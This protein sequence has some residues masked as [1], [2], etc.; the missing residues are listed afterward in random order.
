VIKLANA[1]N[2]RIARNR[3]I[4]V[5]LPTLV[6]LISQGLKAQS[7]PG[8]QTPANTP[9]QAGSQSQAGTQTQ[10]NSTA[11]T[12]TPAQSNL[13]AKA[14]EPPETGLET[15]SA[16]KS[17]EL[18]RR[19]STES[20]PG[21]G[22]GLYEVKQSAELGGRISRFSGSTAMWDTFV[23][24]GTG[25]RLLEYT[26]NMHAKNHDGLF[27]DDLSF[28]NFGYG[29]DPNNVS[30]LRMNK[31][32]IYDFD[33]TFRRDQNIF[34]YDLFANPLNPTISAPTLTNPNLPVLNSPHEVLLTRRMSD[35]TLRLFPQ[36]RI[37]FKLGYSRIV[38]QGNAYSSTHQGTEGLLLEPTHNTTDR[39][40]FEISVKPIART[41]ISYDQFYT[42]YKGDTTDQLNS[43]PFN[44]PGN[45]PVDLGLPWN[46][47]A[48]QPCAGAIQPTG[49]AN[50]AC[51]GYFAYNISNNRIRNN[52]PTEQL[53]F[54]SSYFH[55]FDF[56]GRVNYSDGRSN[57]PAFLESFN[58]L[59]SR[60]AA[61]SFQ[62]NGFTMS[63]RLSLSADGA[64]TWHLTQRMRL[65]DT[66]RYSTFRIP[67]YW[68][69]TT[70]SLFGATL[71]T[72]PNA[73]SAATCPPPFTAA[74]CPQHTNS[75]GPDILNYQLFS[76]LKQNG[77]VNTVELEY[78]FTKRITGHVGFR[79]EHRD[80]LDIN[81]NLETETFFPNKANRG[82]CVGQPILADGSCK[83]TNTH[84][85]N[86]TIFV[87]I[88][89]F[90]AIAGFS[91]RPVDALRI[92][93]DTE[94]FYADNVFT[95]ISPRHM[96]NYRLRANYKAREWMNFG[97]AVTIFENRDNDFDIGN[98]QHN[99][100]YSVY[101]ELAPPGSI[102]GFDASYDYSD[103]F[104]Q[105][106]ICF[107]AT[108]AP[109]GSITCGA[110]FLS[111]IS[112]YTDK[113]HSFSG[114]FYIHPI[115]RVTASAGYALTST[116]GSTLILNPNAPT[117][118]LSFNYHLPVGALAIHISKNF[119]YK[120]NWNY[121]DYHEKSDPGP[122]L[123]RNFRGN[124][125]T[126][127]LRYSM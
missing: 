99:R 7:P 1:K 44:L 4:Q 20:N 10:S 11:Q 50:P 34:D 103:I 127:S 115:P 72:T 85:A 15:D 88:H 112:T 98:L 63:D 84:P 25:P 39:Y 66:Y 5:F 107:V 23:N 40:Q 30:R 26:L 100:S 94:I 96:Q 31:I 57:L 74:T 62:T 33:F 9:T 78:D 65:I 104:S 70:N 38:N 105:T 22:W 120:A 75:S 91:A 37:Q 35:A 47:A 113:S 29:G 64:M 24:M 2:A 53:S 27:F 17:T 49:F 52:F 56:S 122:T 21:V 109:A 58:G 87:P 6:L 123:P 95:R 73:F 86:E 89:G 3:V 114:S 81:N 28:S 116:T 45:I 46:L 77:S 80:I 117:G 67:G 118:P 69:M 124:M 60:T 92:R 76:L 13:R 55:E 18:G 93:F 42:F 108:P 59:I 12:T 16:R 68:N 61:R 106:N 54:Q 48:N 8:P 79:Y 41:N 32:K 90:S 36:S 101:M 51:N 121:Y 43:L 19:Y 102:W 126:L 111:G 14:N 119:E 71:L 82:D 83:T 97:G 110:P 125:F